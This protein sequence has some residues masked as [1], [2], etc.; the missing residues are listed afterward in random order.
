MISINNPLSLSGEG[1]FYFKVKCN[2]RI[3]RESFLNWLVKF[4]QSQEWPVNYFICYLPGILFGF[5]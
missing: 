5:S 4:I 3:V 2:K 1:I